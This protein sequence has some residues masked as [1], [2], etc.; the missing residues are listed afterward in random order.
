MKS[1]FTILLFLAIPVINLVAQ[2]QTISLKLKEGHEYVFEKVDKNYAIRKDNSKIFHSV[3]TK[4]IRIVVQKFIPDE[5]I[6]LTLRHIKNIHFN[7]RIPSLSVHPGS[8]FL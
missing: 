6:N 1:T 7:S 5:N 8:S 4:E 2:E 3:K